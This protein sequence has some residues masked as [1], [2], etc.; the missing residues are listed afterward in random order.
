MSA[1]RPV[2]RLTR[3]RLL[4]SAGAGVLGISVVSTIAGC[5][6]AP[7]ESAPAGGGTPGAGSPEGGS[8]DT[9]AGGWRRVELSFVSAYLLIRGGEAAVVDLGT[10]GSGP[11]I[12]AGLTAAG[13]GW[14]AVRHVILTHQHQDHAGGA[15]EVAPKVTAGSLYGGTADVAA[16]SSPTPLTAV[17]DGDEIFGLQVIGTPGHTAGHIAVFDP[18]T[19]VLV[20][21]DAL[22]TTDGL[23]G[24]DPQYTADMTQA[25]AS[26]RKLAALDV[27][28]ILPGH[29]AP[30]T[31]GAAEAL[32]KLAAAQPPR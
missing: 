21:G 6:T 2:Y 28:V 29:G 12:E 9:L 18:S 3:R 19:G 20:A 30:L 31:D 4:V 32:A 25:A 26:V 7:D 16:I 22:R 10:P 1:F 5:T 27:R 14:D 8:G 17:D 13:A 23:T 11:A 24:P 15:A